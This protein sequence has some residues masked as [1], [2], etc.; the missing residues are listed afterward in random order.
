[1]KRRAS[2]NGVFANSMF[3]GSLSVGLRCGPALAPVAWAVAE[4]DVLA[5]KGNVD[6][7]PRLDPT[8]TMTR[9]A[10]TNARRAGDI[11]V[12]CESRLI[13]D[14]R[15]RRRTEGIAGAGAGRASANIIKAFM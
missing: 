1:M 8:T 5:C 4:A 6:T 12:S 13:R 14:A 11:A 10:P 3:V 7:T 15:C 2:V 9:A